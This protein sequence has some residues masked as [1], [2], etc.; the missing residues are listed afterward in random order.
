M[1]GASWYYL[2]IKR[3]LSC[4]NYACKIITG[5]IFHCDGTT[6]ST[7]NSTLV[8]EFCPL[9]PEKFGI[10]LDALQSGIV[11]DK[12]VLK[13]FLQ[14]FFWG[15]RNLRFDQHMS[16]FLQKYLNLGLGEANEDIC[17]TLLLR[18]GIIL[19]AFNFYCSSFA[20]NLQT[21]TDGVET[22]F[23]IIISIVA[24]ILLI[25]IIGNIQVGT[26]SRFFFCHLP[27]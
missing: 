2:S 20:S 26:K 14:C 27:F 15:L 12:G 17:S 1:I 9:I 4:W 25:Y 11:E 22:S 16:S 10:Y 6:T 13:K 8:N 24:L 3:Q 18:C 5:C 19:T 7:L 21:S 23:A